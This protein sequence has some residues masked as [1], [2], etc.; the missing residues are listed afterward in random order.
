MKLKEL[1]S[2]STTLPSKWSS[3]LDIKWIKDQ[4]EQK[5]A[6]DLGYITEYPDVTTFYIESGQ[7]NSS[8]HILIETTGMGNRILNSLNK[9]L[10]ESGLYVYEHEYCSSCPTIKLMVKAYA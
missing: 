7:T 2:E 8:K 1:I 3:V 9:E 4:C 6:I 5:F 10:K